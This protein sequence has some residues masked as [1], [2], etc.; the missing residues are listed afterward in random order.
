MRAAQNSY[1]WI[2]FYNLS[3]SLNR[4][5]QMKPQDGLTDSLEI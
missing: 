1:A 4:I 3:T 5:S 2:R